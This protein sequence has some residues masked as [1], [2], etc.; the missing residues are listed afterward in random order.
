MG[1]LDGTVQSD[2][3]DGPIIKK[4]GVLETPQPTDCILVGWMVMEQLTYDDRVVAIY[5]RR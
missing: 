4:R 2:E 5:G 1:Q 3:P